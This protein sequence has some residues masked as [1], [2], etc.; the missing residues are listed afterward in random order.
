MVFIDFSTNTNSL[1]M[2]SSAISEDDSMTCT[3]G[4]LQDNLNNDIS[5]CRF[6]IVQMSLL[7]ELFN[8]QRKDF[9]MAKELEKQLNMGNVNEYNLRKR[10]SSTYDKKQNKKSRK[11]LKGQQTLKQVL[12]ERN[13][14]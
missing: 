5:A 13:N 4:R 8:Q 3:C 1:T 12:T 14:N 2:D 7:N 6:C 10:S 11:L 9:L